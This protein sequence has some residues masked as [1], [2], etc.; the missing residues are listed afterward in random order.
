MICD[1]TLES[2]FEYSS[3]PVSGHD[4]QPEAYRANQIPAS[5]FKS[6]DVT[7]VSS[8]PVSIAV[9][10][11]DGLKIAESETFGI[12]SSGASFDEALQD[13]Q[14]EIVYLFD[15]YGTMPD[16]QLAPDTLKLKGIFRNYFHA[17]T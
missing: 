6:G 2:D 9:S 14:D 8:I 7:L 11:A 3:E 15:Y 12:V 17:L 4:F 1:N 5:K 16:E 13:F 10:V